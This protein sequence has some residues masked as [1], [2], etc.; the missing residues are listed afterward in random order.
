MII[1]THSSAWPFWLIVVLAIE[2]TSG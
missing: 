1:S 2:T